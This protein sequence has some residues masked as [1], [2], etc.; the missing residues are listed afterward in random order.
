MQRNMLTQ[1]LGIQMNAQ[2]NLTAAD[3]M[4]ALT[5]QQWADYVSLFMPYENDLIEYATSPE[6][7][8]KAVE[9][10]RTNVD[11][12]F[13]AQRGIAGRRLRANQQALTPE[14]QAAADKQANLSQS[15]AQVGAENMARQATIGRQR[16]I[17]GVG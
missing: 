11:Q 13:E 5:R 16:G 14:E 1:G 2:P 9:S 12:A 4:A 8:T 10:A 6:T 15:L 7:V 3:Q 17:L